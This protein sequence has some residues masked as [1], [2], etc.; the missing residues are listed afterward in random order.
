MGL[1]RSMFGVDRGPTEERST[2]P[3]GYE[4]RSWGRP[5]YS[6]LVLD[7]QTALRSAAVAAC[8][9]VIVSSLLAMPAHSFTRSADGRM[10]ANPSER[11]VVANPVVGLSQRAWV[12]Q[13]ANS[14]VLDGNMFGLVTEYTTSGHPMQVRPLAKNEITWTKDERNVDA[15]MVGGKLER[16]YPVGSLVIGQATPFLLPGQL[17]AQSPV[18]LAMESIGT[19]LAAEKF[20]AQ[21]FGDG[22]HPSAV[23]KHPDPNLTR[24]QAQHLKD[25]I[26]ASWQGREPAVIGSGLEFEAVE[27]NPND[28]QF[29]DLMRFEVEQACRF[30][31]VPPSMVYAA[32]SGSSVTYANVGQN[33][34]Q[35]LKHSLRSWVDDLE[36]FWSSL[37]PGSQVVQLK[38]EGLL[39]MSAKER[40]EL[41]SLRL[42]DGTM[43]VPEVR[44]LEDED[45][46]PGA[47]DDRAITDAAKMLQQIYLAA[48]VVLTNEEARQM[49]TEAGFKLPGP[50]P[51]PPPA[52]ETP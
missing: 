31:G 36:D 2:L 12:A 22:A 23:I 27:V 1:I 41:Y 14:L 42:G 15:G 35:F 30:F 40:H 46:L 19:G 49:V 26:V 38:P 9:R 44:A 5:T 6:G 20:G 29:I 34:I 52:M 33:D 39:R 47:E 50:L 51:A 32:V 11:R 28:S 37:L 25:S 24:E 7:N 43:T 18:D 4:P 10:R 48:D 21:F 8:R 45:P 17:L 13:M 3:A 16:L